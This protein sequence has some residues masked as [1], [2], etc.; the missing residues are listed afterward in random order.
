[1]KYYIEKAVGSKTAKPYV[2]VCVPSGVTEV[3]KRAVIDATRVA[4]AKDAY[5]I[6]EPF[7]AAIGAGLPVMDPTGSMVVDIGGGTTDV[8]TISLGGIVSSRSIRMAGDKIDDSIIYYVRKNYNLLIGE[9]TAE[10]LKINVCLLYT[11]PSP[12]D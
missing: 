4:G 7:A 9:R 5:V 1:M 8:A 12:R 2:M 10:Q 3:E 6:E 11:S